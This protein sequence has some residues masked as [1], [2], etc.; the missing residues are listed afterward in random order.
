VEVLR[1]GLQKVLLHKNITSKNT[2]NVILGS[3]RT[4]SQAFVTYNTICGRN[5]VKFKFFVD[6]FPFQIANHMIQEGGELERRK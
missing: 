6:H 2:S 1:D 3:S 5:R 4:L